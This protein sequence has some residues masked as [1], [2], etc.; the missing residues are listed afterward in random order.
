MISEKMR[1][2]KSASPSA[3]LHQVY[4]DSSKKLDAALENLV[5]PEG[6][7]GAVFASA[8]RILGLDLFDRRETLQKLWSKLVRGYAIDAL[9]DDKARPTVTTEQVRE[10]LESLSSTKMETFKSP[11][12]GDDVRL[13]GGNA[14]GGALIVE[15]RPVH[16]EV[17]AEAPA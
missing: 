14:H 6:C 12:V 8:G 3:E 17:F 13:K 1:R 11:G 2:M 9:E 7:S 5:A 10:W 15:E 4:R 16:V